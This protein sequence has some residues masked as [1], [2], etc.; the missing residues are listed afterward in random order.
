MEVPDN[1]CPELIIRLAV[2]EVPVSFYGEVLDLVSLTK[3]AFAREGG[4]TDV[5][6][7][8]DGKDE[9]GLI[10]LRPPL[11]EACQDS[12]VDGEIVLVVRED[13][14]ELCEGDQDD[15]ETGVV[16]LEEIRG[17]GERRQVLRQ[18]GNVLR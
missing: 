8:D 1:A 16:A 6:I 14:I 15:V 12:T 5:R 13:L 11:L 17:D 7:E 9:D 2:V 18:A 10:L 3:R 4:D